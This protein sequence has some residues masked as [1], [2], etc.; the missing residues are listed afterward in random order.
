MLEQR[1]PFCGILASGTLLIFHIIRKQMQKISKD[2]G[3][4]K[5]GIQTETSEPD[6]LSND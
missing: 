4:P 6:C 1:V 2:K 3:K 5:N